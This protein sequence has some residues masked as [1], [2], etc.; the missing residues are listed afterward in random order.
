MNVIKV[1]NSL[2]FNKYP[3]FDGVRVVN[4]QCDNKTFSGV[5]QFD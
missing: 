4:I 1:V 5:V 3:E 2:N